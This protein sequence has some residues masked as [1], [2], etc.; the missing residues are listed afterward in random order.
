MFQET[1]PGG[2]ARVG[3]QWTG[4]GSG[5]CGGGCYGIHFGF[6]ASV[7]DV[8]GTFDVAGVVSHGVVVVTVGMERFALDA[9]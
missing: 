3:T 7:E 8:F 5:G 4:F 2:F 6:E 1:S 9:A